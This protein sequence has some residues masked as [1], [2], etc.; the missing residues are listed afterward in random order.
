MNALAFLT[1]YLSEEAG[2]ILQVIGKINRFGLESSRPGSE[3]TNRQLLVEELNDFQAGIELL[4]EYLDENNRGG[5]PGLGDRD[6]IEKRKDKFQHF[7][8]ISI[9]HGF[10]KDLEYPDPV[11]ASQ[12][13]EFEQPSE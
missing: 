13:T 4:K 12:L 7:A 11:P 10:V 9:Q 1:L 8:Q 5:L 3:K 2:E 6:F